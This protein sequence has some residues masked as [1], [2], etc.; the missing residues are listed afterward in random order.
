MTAFSP[1]ADSWIIRYPTKETKKE[2]PK[3]RIPVAAHLEDPCRKYIDGS[4]IA[5][6][7]NKSLGTGQLLSFGFWV[8][9]WIDRAR[10]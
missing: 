3:K 5:V 1:P 8:W 4:D 9:S 2:E 7:S 10:Y 6:K